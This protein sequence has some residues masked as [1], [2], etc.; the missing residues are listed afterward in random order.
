MNIRKYKGKLIIKPAKSSV[1]RFLANIREIIK[2]KA[3]VKVE[4]LI[5]ILNPKIRGWVNYYRHV[6]AKKTFSYVDNAIFWALWRWCKR[7]HPKK[8]RRWI[9]NRY[10]R[11]DKLR[12]WVFSTEIKGKDNKK[13]YLNLIQA[14]KTPIRRH[15][16]IKA[17]ATPYDPIYQEYLDKRSRVQA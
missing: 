11:S 5:Q 13:F 9:K 4:E 1:K 12:N 3:T 2:T 14:D 15:I 7:R 16:K 10:F 6:C 8:G 17:D